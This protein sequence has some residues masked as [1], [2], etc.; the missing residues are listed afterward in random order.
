LFLFSRNHSLYLLLMLCFSSPSLFSGPVHD[1]P[2][3]RLPLISS[4]CC[5]TLLLLSWCN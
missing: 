5:Y 1:L 3:R 2:D 4:G